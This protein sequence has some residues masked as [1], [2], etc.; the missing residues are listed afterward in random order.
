[1]AGNLPAACEAFEA[2]IRAAGGIAIQ[3]LGIGCDGHLGFNE[4]SSSLGS[5]T[6][7]KTLTTQTR[8]DN[9]RFFDD[10][11]EVP[12]HC[13]TQGLGTILD[14]KHLILTAFGSRKAH[15]V[16][17]AVEGPVTAMCPA[18]V[19]Q[20]HP[21]VTVIVD[22]AAAA[23]LTMADYYRSTYAAKPAWQTL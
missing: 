5:R 11:R 22:E 2:A 19:I 20:F 7:I 15:A 21:H 4:P 17:T 23:G 6:R 1:M 9:A 3:I 8:R 12:T 13:I 10:P 18:S 16:A 14:A